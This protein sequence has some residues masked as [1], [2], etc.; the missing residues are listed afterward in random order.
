MAFRRGFKAE[1]EQIAQEVRADLGSSLRDRL[2]PLRLAHELDIPVWPLS[3]LPTAIPHLDD[4]ADAVA[5]L[6]LTDRAALSAVTVFSG[7]A[8]VIVHNDA[9]APARQASNLTHE[10]AH[11]LLLHPQPPPSTGADAAN[12]PSTSRMKPTGSAVPSLSPVPPPG[13]QP[14]VD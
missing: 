10:L 12:G 6:S 11:A 3:R 9:H 1:A 2:D 13:G 5:Y 7:T 8:R 4:I 14:A